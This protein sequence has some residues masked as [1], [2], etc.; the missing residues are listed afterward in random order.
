MR[1]KL[2]MREE[3]RRSKGKSGETRRRRRRASRQECL[4]RAAVKEGSVSPT[5]RPRYKLGLHKV[6]TCLSGPRAS[7][8]ECFQAAKSIPGNSELYDPLT[9]NGTSTAAPSL[10]CEDEEH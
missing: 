4:A 8:E 5:S 9:L 2:G 10:R 3:H 1:D 7:K 6:D